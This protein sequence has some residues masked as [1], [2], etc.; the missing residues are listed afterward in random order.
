MKNILLNK[1]KDA[2]KACDVEY[3]EEILIEQP[4][5]KKNGDYSTNIAMK[6][7]GKLRKNPMDIAEQIKNA[8]DMSSLKNIEAVRPGFINFYVEKN[9]LIDNINTINEKKYEYGKSNEGNNKKVNIEFVSANPTGIMHL[10]NARGGAYGDSL[11]RIL[12][13]AGYDVTK[14]YYVNDAGVQI[15]NLGLSIKARYLTIIGIPTEIPENGY[16]GNEILDIAK[17]LY[18]KNGDSLKDT[19]LE[20]FKKVGTEFLLGRIKS[21]LREYGIEYDVF[22]SEKDI[23]KNYSIEKFMNILD[24]NGY[25]YENEGAKWFKC[26]AI[27]DDKDHVLQKEDGTYTYLM[28]DIMYHFDK[29]SRGFDKMIDILGTDH[30]GYV[31]RLKSSVKALGNDADKLEVKLLQLVRLV[32]NGEVVKMSKRSGKS[33]GLKDLIDEV[34]VNAAR[35]YFAKYSLDTQM[36][37]NLTLAKQNNNENPVYYINYAYARICSI[38]SN[39]ENP[40]NIEKYSTLDNENAYDI[41]KELYN[42]PSVLSSAANKELP[43]L[44]ANYAYDL[45]SKFH[46]YYDKV[47]IISDNEAATKENINLL[48]AVKYTLKTV[49]NLIGVEPLERM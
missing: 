42:W 45:A 48:F 47:R 14:E 17:D 25:I 32:E 10:G 35:Y 43:H 41:L 31:A 23:R 30:H 5:D 28:P 13:F 24:E 36:D 9:Y 38:L 27:F 21:D 40:F 1:I 49:L 22:T 19:D 26:S 39:Y 33:I 12:T 16:H 4:K 3:D 46:A 6:L 20:Y 7:A 29:Y 11:A 34:G 15:D 44:I 37:F 18:E 8:I 2:L